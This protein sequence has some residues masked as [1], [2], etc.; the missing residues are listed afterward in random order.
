MSFL[1]RGSSRV[2]CGDEGSGS[3]SSSS[4][5][6]SSSNNSSSSDEV[7]YLSHAQLIGPSTTSDCS[8]QSLLLILRFNLILLHFYIIKLA[9]VP[10]EPTL[11][12]YKYLRFI[13]SCS[14]SCNSTVVVVVVTGSLYV[15]LY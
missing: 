12:A 7:V 6:S 15:W 9:A 3:S 8:W 14:S 2:G 11:G 13:C 5:S 1:P 4:T 10:C